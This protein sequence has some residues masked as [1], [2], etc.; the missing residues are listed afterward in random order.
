MVG[1]QPSPLFP[2]RKKTVKKRTNTRPRQPI[3]YVEEEEAGPA[4]ATERKAKKAKKP[5]VRRGIQPSAPMEQL[6]TE[7]KRE[8]RRRRQRRRMIL[9]LAVVAAVCALAVV[10][11][12]NWNVL[13]PNKVLA[14]LQDL[15]GGGT[16]S[17]PVDLSGT[18]AHRI[19]RSDRYTVVL[20]D[21]HIVYLN[22]SGAE[23]ARYGCGY[24][25]PLLRA[26][27]KYVLTAEQ[28]GCR[29]LLTTRN[30]TV[31]AWEAERDI[32]AVSLNEKGQ[33][34][35]LTNGPQGYAFQ[36][37]VY[38]DEGEVLY[39]RDSNRTVIDVA[40]SPD[41]A[42]LSVTGVEATD[43]TLN[44]RVEV[45]ALGSSDPD[46]RCA[47]TAED[48]LLSRTAYL[49]E[50]TLAA[51]SEQ[52]VVLIHTENGKTQS[53]LPEGMRV[54]GY[55]VSGDSVALAVRAYGDTAG[56][57]V[58]V[59]SSSGS[60]KSYARFE[61]EFRHLSG[62]EGMYVLLTDSTAQTISANGVGGKI[63]VAADSRQAVY[64]DGHV[65][66]MGLNR[67]ESFTIK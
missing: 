49:S 55:A 35:V 58:Q 11:W 14:W 23:V 38:D 43:G 40:L 28:S 64:A 42:T 7:D 22:S 32:R 54:L 44:T 56:G 48:T 20:T 24:S 26:E 1:R 62:H 2:K 41:G 8:I 6:S 4:V 46:P 19:V 67:L 30:K 34:A 36:I 5:P 66:I 47:Y 57:E 65:V 53:Y 52:G 17:Y 33:A 16:G 31:L 37:K 13:A 50:G 10:V 60:V 59:I 39:T 29:L 45:Y 3:G 18:G 12:L 21:S 25:D 61:G 51:V 9:R 63:A 15:V 27:G